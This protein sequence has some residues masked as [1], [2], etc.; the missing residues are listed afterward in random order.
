[1]GPSLQG[2]GDARCRAAGRQGRAPVFVGLA[3]PPAPGAKDVQIPLGSTSGNPPKT[4]CMQKPLWPLVPL[5]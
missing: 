1:M 5:K 2:P 3:S 4:H